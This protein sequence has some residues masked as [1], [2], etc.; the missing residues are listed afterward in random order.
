[1][2]EEGF[3]N[4]VLV[5]NRGEIA[6]RVMRA[7]RELGISTVAVYS[8]ADKNALF[9]K[10][11][12]EAYNIGKPPATMSYLN[13]ERIVEVALKSNAEAIHPGYGF[14]AENSLFARKVEEAGIVFM[15][16]PPE[17]MDAMGSKIDAKRTMKEAGVPVIPGVEKP[18]TDPEEAKEIAH[19]IGYPVMLKA[20]AGGGGIGMTMVKNDEQ[21][22]NQL[23][24]TRRVALNTFGDGTVF[25]EK[26]IEEPRHIEFQVLS[27]THGHHIHVRERECSIQRRHQK[28]VEETPS[29]VMTEE[30]REKMGKAAVTVAKTVGYRSAGTVEF[31]YSKGEFYFLEMNTRLQVEHPITEIV[32]S[33]DLVKEQLRVA[34]GMELGYSQEDIQG[35]GWAIEARINAE[36]TATFLPAPGK[37]TRYREP[38]GPGVRIDSGVYEGY[39]IPPFYDSLIAKLIVWGRDRKEAIARMN[40]SLYEYEIKGVKTNILLHKVILREPA[41]K[42]G[43]L[44]TNF[45]KDY[46]IQ[47]KVE[48]AQKEEKANKAESAKAA[49]I[50][51]VGAYVNAAAKAQQISKNKQ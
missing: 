5:A 6:L 42:E 17:A 25:L 13:I 14:L 39:T 30:L 18:L 7:C 15:G 19:E 37:I 32:T 41:F 38:G 4:K 23:E 27:D 28:V 35:H 33:V 36:D 48:I 45:I 31:M 40:R 46:D 12:D 49:A 26:F 20:S 29:P 21:L 9:K 10:Y 11:A 43:K 51:T 8:D 3:I 2:T 50:A 34:S 22:L 47:R 24:S 44:T 1:M 16:P